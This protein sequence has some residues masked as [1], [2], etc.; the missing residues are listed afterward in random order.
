MSYIPDMGRS[1]EYD[2]SEPAADARAGRAAGQATAAATAA[3]AAAAAGFDP[4]ASFQSGTGGVH[5]PGR[6]LKVLAPAA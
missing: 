3:P 4:Y 2:L 6:K 5:A 1:S